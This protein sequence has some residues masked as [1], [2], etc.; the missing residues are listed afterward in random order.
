MA[1]VTQLR[2]GGRACS[3]VVLALLSVTGC[4]GTHSADNTAH[5][6]AIPEFRSEKGLDAAKGQTVALIGTAKPNAKFSSYLLFDNDKPIHVTFATASATESD[7]WPAHLLERRVRAVGTLEW[8]VQ[9]DVNPL[10]QTISGPSFFIL[11]VE[12]AEAYDENAGQ[13]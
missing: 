7:E 8:F 10:S 12:S 4:G 9:E 1:S 11:K 3:L 6:N 2:F 13:R 5:G